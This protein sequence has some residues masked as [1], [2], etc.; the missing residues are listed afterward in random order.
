MSNTRRALPLIVVTLIAFGSLAFVVSQG[1]SP[2]LGL[3]LQGGVSVVFIAVEADDVAE[4][5]GST[6]T[7]T[8][9]DLTTTPAATGPT[10]TTAPGATN[11]RSTSP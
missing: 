1:W 2:Q 11:T 4:V 3:D 10:V 7:T 6:T 9:T 5:P 8:I